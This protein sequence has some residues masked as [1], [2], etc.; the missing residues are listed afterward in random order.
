MEQPPAAAPRHHYVL[1][2]P[3][4]TPLHKS[5]QRSAPS[6]AAVKRHLAA[7][8]LLGIIP[9]KSGLLVVDVDVP[10]DADRIDEDALEALVAEHP[11]LASI[12]TPSGGRHLIYHRPPG[13]EPIGNAKWELGPLQGDIRCDRGFVVIWSPQGWQDILD[14]DHAASRSARHRPAPPR[15]AAA[16]RQGAAEDPRPPARTRARQP[17]AE[18]RGCSHDGPRGHPRGSSTATTRSTPPPT[19][20]ADSAPAKASTPNTGVI[21]CWLKPAAWA[22][23]RAR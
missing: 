20:S 18:L 13:A 11:P 3:D 6:E 12:P 9:G 23:T 8:G 5:W 16:R 2:R 7:D 19:R 10:P 22:S 21:A 15:P 17:R 1:C 4:K 14:A